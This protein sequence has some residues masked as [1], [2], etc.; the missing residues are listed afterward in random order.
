MDIGHDVIFSGREAWI[1]NRDSDMRFVA[2]RRD[3]LYYIREDIK[4]AKAATAKECSELK[5]HYRLGHLN[6]RDLARSIWDYVSDISL[7][8]IDKLSR[9]RVASCV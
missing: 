2:D 8:D 3:D 7:K 1:V 4:C 9:Y 6:A 5:W